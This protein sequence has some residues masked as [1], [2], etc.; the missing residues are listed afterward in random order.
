MLRG[1]HLLSIQSK[2]RLI[3]LSPASWLEAD[4]ARLFFLQPSLL[5]RGGNKSCLLFQWLSDY[6]WFPAC[7]FLWPPIMGSCLCLRQLLAIIIFGPHR[8]G[9]QLPQ[10]EWNRTS[11]LHA[12]HSA[13]GN[14]AYVLQKAC[15]IRMSLPKEAADRAGRPQHKQE[16]SMQL[17]CKFSSLLCSCPVIYQFSLTSRASVLTSQKTYWVSFVLPGRLQGLWA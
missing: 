13:Q 15:L 16:H 11:K 7:H 1:Q 2:L 4:P 5:E 10:A 6:T 12:P 17:C 8:L 14:C 9:T 3:S